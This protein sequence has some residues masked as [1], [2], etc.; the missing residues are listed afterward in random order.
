[1][2]SQSLGSNTYRIEVSGWDR[3]ESFFV[4]KTQLDWSEQH[5]KKI[6]LRHSVREGAVLFVRLIH[7]TAAGHSFPVAYQVKEVGPADAA[8]MYAVSLVQI[9]PRSSEGDKREEMPAPAHEEKHT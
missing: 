1:M 4:E 7:P 8:G 5:G 3:S 9:H 2:S 6:F